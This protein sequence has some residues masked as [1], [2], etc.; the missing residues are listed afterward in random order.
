M[1]DTPPPIPTSFNV[2]ALARAHGLSRRTIARRLAK[3]GTPPAHP[4]VQHGGHGG[5]SG[6]VMKSAPSAAHAMAQ[7]GHTLM[8]ATFATAAAL[9]S[10][11]AFF[12]VTGMTTTFADAVP[13]MVMICVLEAAKLVTASWLARHWHGAPLL[14]RL[15]L[16]VMALALMVLT[17]VGTYGY[18][19]RAHLAHQVESIE[20]IER[21]A[22]PLAQRI[23]LATP[24]LRDLDGRIVQRDDL[25]RAATSRGYTRTAMALVGDQAQAR[26]ALVAQ[27]QAAAGRLAAL[28]VEQAG[29]ELRRARVAGEAGSALYLARLFDSGDTE[30]AVRLITALLVLVLDPLA[31]LLTI[32]ASRQEI[33]P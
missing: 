12:A 2:S 23:E 32:A 27:R 22:A 25:V 24:E 11:S 13:V 28:K 3:G 8:V 1:T 14:L 21:D 16:T 17:A 30:G 10:I 7:R 4:R 9:A 20:T 19:T 5:Q 6:Q 29:V 26:A 15:P 31:I 18:L 33:F